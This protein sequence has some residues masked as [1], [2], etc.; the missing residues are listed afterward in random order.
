MI[1]EYAEGGELFKYIIE[2]GYLS[3]E[4]SR[5]IFHQIIDGIYYLH[6]L[7]ICHRD[8]KPENIL[9]D[10]KDKKR[11]KI[12]DF[13]LSNLYIYSNSE[14]NK[15]LLETPC[16]SPGY[17]PPEM[18]LG[19]KYDGIMTD[20]WSCGIILY[21]MMFGCL[22]FDDT[23]EELL[24]KKI[25]K[26]KYEFPDDINVS[27]EAKNLINSILVVNPKYRANINDI[28]NNKWFSQ[29][30]KPIIGLFDSISEIP[31]NNLILKEMVR[32]GYDENKIVNYIKNNNHNNI[33]TLYYL[34]VKQK[35]KKGIETESDLIS[36]CFKEYI[37]KQYNKLKHNNNPISL[38]EILMHKEESNYN[39]KII[40]TYREN[41]KKELNVNGYMNKTIK[42][43]NSNSNYVQYRS[44]KNKNKT[45]SKEK[46]QKQ[47]FNS[48][49]NN[50][51]INK[52]KNFHNI[53]SAKTNILVKTFDT[54]KNNKLIKKLAQLS[55]S[56]KEMTD[57][58]II[59]KM[60][61]S[62]NLKKR[63]DIFINLNYF[64]IRNNKSREKKIKLDIKNNS[65]K[66]K[67]IMED[68]YKD[69]NISM[70][71]NKILNNITYENNKT[72][73]YNNKNFI[74]MLPSHENFTYLQKNK[75]KQK[76][77]K[78][79][80]KEKL[81]CLSFLINNK[82][83]HSKIDSVE[84]LLNNLKTLR[85]KKNKQIMI[86]DSNSR[87]KSSSVSKTKSKSNSI[88][89]KIQ[90]KKGLIL[91]QSRNYNKKG[92]TKNNK[93]KKLKNLTNEKL[94][95]KHNNTSN[96]ERNSLFK[97]KIELI[98]KK[99]K[100][101]IDLSKSKNSSVKNGTKNINDNKNINN[102]VNQN[103]NRK[104]I[105]NYMNNLMINKSIHRN[106]TINSER[107]K[108][109][110]KNNKTNISIKN[111]KSL[112]FSI[113]IKDKEKDK[114]Y[115]LNLSKNLKEKINKK[116]LEKKMKNRLKYKNNIKNKLKEI[117]KQ[118]FIDNTSKTLNTINIIDSHTKEMNN[119]S[120]LK[121]FPKRKI[122]DINPKFIKVYNTNIN[123]NRIIKLG[124]CN[125]L[126]LRNIFLFHDLKKPYT[127]RKNQKFL[128][129]IITK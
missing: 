105:I 118:S 11:I 41:K 123:N 6:R 90:Q 129:E 73:N 20:I 26:G 78:E 112:N 34:L 102:I 45:N 33:T 69:I 109:N 104:K 24:Y 97:K 71:N 126:K 14:K 51:N 83:Y 84:Q 72:I 1:M 65:K 89:N 74:Y 32:M 38:K 98:L 35:L 2:K 108:R 13:G 120:N 42:N 16:G 79:K 77:T 117:N 99:K 88:R 43:N 23:E 19:M 44:R 61:I 55:K 28:K 21:A 29:N 5:N 95:I 48:G 85:I 3:E 4:E 93:E 80:E 30:Y 82:I 125:S 68:S 39:K 103:L 107:P 54:D 9:F 10:S 101:K 87:S 36:N 57:S 27:K 37:E 31:V 119:I 22:P 92:V 81:N 94:Y 116:N 114:K 70:N 96:K 40:D 111:D 46:K 106:H 64:K 66:N 75:I 58:G 110:E 86:S 128:D 124:N 121:I 62:Q 100:V 76:G 49:I 17:A 47:Y 52:I 15:D 122:D 127:Y 63:K 7:G 91:D 60:K 113:S 18:I 67:I 115:E 53:E 8:L 50:I 25:I 56:T 59:N 12:I